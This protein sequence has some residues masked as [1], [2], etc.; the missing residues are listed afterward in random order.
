VVSRCGSGAESSYS[1]NNL[2]SC[3][4]SDGVFSKIERLGGS[5]PGGG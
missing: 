2:S 4:S 3:S 5:D 1:S